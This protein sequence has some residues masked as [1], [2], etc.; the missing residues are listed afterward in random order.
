ML[1]TNCRVSVIIVNWNTR[2]LVLE[3]IESILTNHDDVPVEIV[4]VDNNSQDGSSEAVA[5]RFPE[6]KLIASEENLG[7]AAGNNLGIRY[8]TGEYI[9]F[10]NPDTLILGS[11]IKYMRDYLQSNA[12]VGAVGCRINNPDGSLQLSHWNSFPSVGWLMHK[13]FRMDKLSRLRSKANYA[14]TP[15]MSVAHLLGAC[16]MSPAGLIRQLHGFDETYFLYL[17]ETDLCCRIGESG[18]EVHYA[19]GAEIVH[20]GQQSSM[21][22]T[23]WTN[24][25]YVLNTFRFISRHRRGSIGSL[26]LLIK[27][28][29]AIGVLLCIPVWSVK[30]LLNRPSRAVASSKLSGYFRSLKEIPHLKETET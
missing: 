11:A 12:R 22:A 10:L 3:C 6:V 24:S 4:V 15:P 28:A 30:W 26:P 14:N 1:I 8:A 5:E 23:Q 9:L 16:I 13:S 19:P 20:I 18:Y 17:E 2:D 21:Q 29:L 25:Q 7:F 27:A